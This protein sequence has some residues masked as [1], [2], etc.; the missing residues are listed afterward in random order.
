MNGTRHIDI[1]LAPGFL[2]A[3]VFQR[4]MPQSQHR[5]FLD[6]LLPL[7]MGRTAVDA[8]LSECQIRKI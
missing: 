4:V 7:L 6:P 1:L 8:H 5:A 3:L 2:V